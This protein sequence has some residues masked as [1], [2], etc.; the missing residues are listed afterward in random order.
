MHK[1]VLLIIPVYLTSLFGSIY[2]NL[3]KEFSLYLP[4]FLSSMI[5]YG[6]YLFLFSV[7]LFIVCII[8]LVTLVSSSN[9][10]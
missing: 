4:N 1:F 10:E 9:N 3:A 6:N 8:M 2:L 7:I 5:N